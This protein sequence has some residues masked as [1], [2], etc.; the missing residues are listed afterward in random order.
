MLLGPPEEIALCALST[1]TALA[2]ASFNLGTYTSLLIHTYSLTEL[3]LLPTVFF[4]HTLSTHNCSVLLLFT[5]QCNFQVRLDPAVY[6][7]QSLRT[8]HCYFNRTD[9][10]YSLLSP[11]LLHHACSRLWFEEREHTGEHLSR[12]LLHWRRSGL[13]WT[14]ISLRSVSPFSTCSSPSPH[15]PRIQAAS[16]PA[17]TTILRWLRLV[18]RLPCRSHRCPEPDACCEAGLLPVCLSWNAA[19]VLTAVISKGVTRTAKEETYSAGFL[20][21]H[22]PQLTKACFPWTHLL[23]HHPTHP[24]RTHSQSMTAYGRVYLQ[25]RLIHWDYLWWIQRLW[26]P[27]PSDKKI[28]PLYCMWTTKCSSG[29]S[30]GLHSL[31][32]TSI[33]MRR[34]LTSWSTSNDTQ[35]EQLPVDTDHFRCGPLPVWATSGVGHFHI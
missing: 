1:H 30:Q 8:M 7:S 24:A 26:A 12:Y 15:G 19:Q 16:S 34:A 10:Y 3:Y 33:C 2:T 25:R 5:R 14:N 28:I 22:C 17:L 13:A 6:Y 32:S 18:S 9:F 29:R 35:K 20:Q 11:P 4:C 21:F 31:M 23:D 27:P